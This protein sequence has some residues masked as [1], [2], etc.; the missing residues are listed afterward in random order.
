MRIL[1]YCFRDDLRLHDNPALT[2][3]CQNA[4]QLLP[5]CVVPT[6]QQT[7]WGFARTSVRRQSFRHSA[8]GGLERA[9]RQRGSRLLVVAADMAGALPALVVRTGAQAVV[10]EQIATPYEQSEL[11][12]LQAQGVTVHAFWQSTV[13]NPDALPWPIGGLPDVFTSF[14]QKVEAAGLDVRQPLPEPDLP[15]V[16]E[17]DPTWGMP[18]TGTAPDAAHPGSSFPFPQ[19]AFAG[20]EHTAR[21]HLR[22]YMAKGLP[23]HY[24]ETRNQLS[25][26]EFSTKFSPWLACGALSARSVVHAVRQFEQSRGATRSSYWILFELLWRDYF[27]FLHLKYGARLYHASGLGSLAPPGHDPQAFV[28]WCAGATGQPL[29]D[30]GMRELA[31]TGYISN[32]MR[33]IVASYLVHDLACD[34]RAGA[35]WF[36]SQLIDYD[37]YSNQGNWLYI[38]GRG[39]DPR[40]GRRFNPEK[41]QRDYDPDGSYCALWGTA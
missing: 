9:L 10:C 26:I 38:A 5:V 23:H 30:A 19:P 2:W 22:N 20:D 24:L 15:P 37:C 17:I 25:G 32:R 8:V 4:D 41:Q 28:R 31:E 35:A 16:P 39:T 12:A 1:V 33:Q 18:M 40:G 6:Q 3:A 13:L 34:W 11:L 7:P 36:E 29:I 14:R 21:T 27:R